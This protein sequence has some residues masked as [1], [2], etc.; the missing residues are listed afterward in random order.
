MLRAEHALS[1]FQCAPI[2]RLG[3]RIVAKTSLAQGHFIG[4]PRCLNGIPIEP[5]KRQCAERISRVAN[6]RENGG[7][8]RVPSAH[9]TAKLRPLTAGRIAPLTGIWLND[10]KIAFMEKPSASHESTINA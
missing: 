8:A 1:G 6:P 5:G 2:Q 9:F 7:A 3:R 4:E 10:W